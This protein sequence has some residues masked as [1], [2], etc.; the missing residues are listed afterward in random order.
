MITNRIENTIFDNLDPYFDF[1]RKKW[2]EK[3]PHY[4]FAYV[5]CF[6]AIL[7]MI[8]LGVWVDILIGIFRLEGP[9]IAD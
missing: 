9:N 2:T 3:E 7:G 5:S 8:L 6:P 1:F 4:T